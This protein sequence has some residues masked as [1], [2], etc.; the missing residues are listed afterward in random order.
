[1]GS[2]ELH[3]AEHIFAR[4]LQNL[5][6]NLHVE[7]VD[8]E[9]GSVGI[10]IFREKVDQNTLLK[11]EAEV[12][13]AIL[14]ALPV[15]EFTFRS[16]EE[17]KQEFPK[18]RLNEERLQGQESLRL[19]KIGDYDFAMCKHQHVSNTSQITA[20]ALTKI[21]YPEGHT[22]IE[23]LASADA[24]GYL[25]KINDAVLSISQ[26]RN[27][28]PEKIAEKYILAES[29]I[30]KLEERIKNLFDAMVSTGQAVFY[31]KGFEVSV[32]YGYAKRYIEKSGSARLALMNE[33]QVLCL[34][35][36]ESRLDMQ[37][38]GKALKDGA[39]FEGG[40]KEHSLSGRISNPDRA[41]EII[42]EFLGG[43]L[44]AV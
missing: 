33:K 39:G 38:L 15:N 14:D 34:S 6:V 18:V 41:K 37:E 8:T 28:A 42:A 7:K 11:A 10:A 36:S 40:I 20:F 17:A 1:M 43:R 4:A 3:T 13:S 22:K 31:I 32:F 12:N 25:Q 27:F 26:Q 21:S 23:F 35:G 9:S 5:G 24:L 2:K 19:I 16:I 44:V 29:E 30:Q